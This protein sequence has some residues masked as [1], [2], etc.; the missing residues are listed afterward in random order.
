MRCASRNSLLDVDQTKAITVFLLFVTYTEQ[1][2]KSQSAERTA[3]LHPVGGINDFHLVIL[4]A[5]FRGRNKVAHFR[6]FEYS[7]NL[8]PLSRGN[9]PE[10]FAH[11]NLW[12]HVFNALF[13]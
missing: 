9:R 10:A 3:S 6:K 4:V 12:S 13:R 2:G 1:D 7:M 5:I 8:F 11:R